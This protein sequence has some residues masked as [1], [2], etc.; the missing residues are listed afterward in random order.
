MTE[1]KNI[2]DLHY[3]S[4][5]GEDDVVRDL[6]IKEIDIEEKS[7]EGMS[8]LHI[9]VDNANY[10]TVKLLLDYG[11]NILSKSRYGY[12]PIHTAA[13]YYG[14]EDVVK[15]LLERG[16]LVDS[17]NDLGSTPLHLAAENGLVEIVVTLID[18][19]ATINILDSEALSP[20]YYA[21][22][23]NSEE[24]CRLLLENGAD[25]SLKVHDNE[26]LLTYAVKRS[27][28]RVIKILLSAGLDHI[29]ESGESIFH[30]AAKEGYGYILDAAIESGINVDFKDSNNRTMLDYACSNNRDFAIKTLIGHGA[31]V[32]N[33]NL[34]HVAKSG[35]KDSIIKLMSS[36]PNTR[37]SDGSSLVHLLVEKD[38]LELLIQLLEKTTEG[39]DLQD[40]SGNSALHLAT[41]KYDQSYTS[42]LLDYGADPTLINNDGN[43]IINRLHPDISYNNLL[44]LKKYPELFLRKNSYN[45]SPLECALDNNL[46]K[47][48]PALIEI[49][50]GLGD[51]TVYKSGFTVEQMAAALG[52]NRALEALIKRN[53]INDKNHNGENLLFFLL[54][55]EAYDKESSRIKR[56]IDS[57]IE[58][59]IKNRDGRTPL[60]IAAQR[61]HS[62]ALDAL[63]SGGANLNITDP[64]GRT[65][66]HHIIK[67]GWNSGFRELMDNGA[68]P[69]IEDRDGITPRDLANGIEKYNF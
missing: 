40:N 9:A 21:V 56:L 31:T 61:G 15:L 35:D 32:S 33:E 22:K 69:D 20:L 5:K 50:Y 17:L 45:K 4:Q 13:S 57:G 18:S 29:D 66:L 34:I 65:A 51:E 41:Y 10:S 42:L 54:P 24:V 39:I 14:N 58:T 48:Y 62:W 23:S 8:P 27:K 28:E 19:R 63:I 52:D 36:A 30:W 25:I 53:S 46:Y 16:A 6:L 59:D 3:A 67:K 38:E 7:A 12:L 1:L 11:A 44:R 55:L 64:Q 60:I 43:N 26:S 68:D 37:F 2:K 49:Y 47:T